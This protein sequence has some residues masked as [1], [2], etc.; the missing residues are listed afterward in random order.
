[1]NREERNFNQRKRVV[2]RTWRRKDT[3]LIKELKTKGSIWSRCRE[4]NIALG[5]TL[6]FGRG[7][8]LGFGEHANIT[9]CNHTL[10]CLCSTG[11]SGVCLL[12]PDCQKRPLFDSIMS[13]NK[14]CTRKA[15]KTEL[16]THRHF[17]IVNKQTTTTRQ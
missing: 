2:L 13:G 1:M 9:V 17:S 4:G 11:K 7:Q 12:S 6:E 15:S 5:E 3:S 8:N 14:L 16:S 10:T